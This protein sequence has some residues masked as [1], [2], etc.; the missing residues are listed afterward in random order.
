M[1]SVLQLYTCILATGR[2]KR[3][4]INLIGNVANSLFGVLDSDYAE[5]LSQTIDEIKNNENYLLKLLRS[6]RLRP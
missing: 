5:R 3:G 2:V 6:H 4:A 1:A